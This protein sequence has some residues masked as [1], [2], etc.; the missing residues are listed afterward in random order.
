MH[1]DRDTYNLLHTTCNHNLNGK[2]ILEQ[3][4]H[5]LILC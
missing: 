5:K 1:T 4:Y 2:H 3:H